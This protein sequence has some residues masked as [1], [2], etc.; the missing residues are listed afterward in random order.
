M[1]LENVS[2]VP[3][4]ANTLPTGTTGCTNVRLLRQEQRRPTRNII[5]NH[6]RLLRKQRGR[7]KAH[8]GSREDLCRRLILANNGRIVTLALRTIWP[9]DVSGR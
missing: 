5:D 4:F 2:Q 6:G 3:V 1:A 9:G 7:G 8:D